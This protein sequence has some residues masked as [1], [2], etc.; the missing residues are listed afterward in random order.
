[1][2]AITG[3]SGQL[4]RLVIQALLKRVPASDL[5]ALVRDTGK[6]QD[7]ITQGV[8]VRV[9]DYSQPQSLI[10]A[11][12][13]VERL[14]L[15]SSS[16][17]GQRTAQHKAVIDAAKQV[18][19]T[20]LAYTSL[21]HADRSALAL[22]TEHRETEQLLQDSGIPHALLRNG[23]YH[24]NY[25][26]G[27]P[28]A[29]AHGAI[30]GCAQQ[31][32]IA[33]AARADYALAAAEVL[34]RENQAGCVYELAG[35]TAYTLSELADEVTRQAGTTVRYHDMSEVEYRA[36]LM[37]VGFPQ[38]FAALL[39]DSDTAAAQGHLY[40]TGDDLRHLLQRP[41]TPISAAVKSA[42]SMTL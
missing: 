31:G 3:A 21:L 13:G 15:I 5:V 40:G 25:T 14:L 4:G 29:L 6:V 41:S 24:E 36:A 39:A 23:W 20:L 32:K 16:E 33:S 42:L 19:V 35:E 18:G 38:A 28:A 1:M 8:T 9:A 2:I 10:P 7:L 22:A 12:E 11:L 27:I 17:I 37:A 34:M 26:A 30:L